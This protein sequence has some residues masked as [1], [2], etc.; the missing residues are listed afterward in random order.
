LLPRGWGPELG[1]IARHAPGLSIE[2]LLFSGPGLGQAVLTW[3][4]PWNGTGERNASTAP[5]TAATRARGLV[6]KEGVL[7]AL[8]VNIPWPRRKKDDTD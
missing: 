4:R 5:A 2:L 6:R 7:F 1:P 8:V 3:S